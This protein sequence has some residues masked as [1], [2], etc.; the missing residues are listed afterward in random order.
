MQIPGL[1]L[2]CFLERGREPVFY[3]HTLGVS[4]PCLILRTT[5]PAVLGGGRM[6]RPRRWWDSEEKGSSP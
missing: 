4:D 2:T 3:A 6:K 1:A 5:A